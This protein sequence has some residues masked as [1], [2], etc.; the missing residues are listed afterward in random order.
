MSDTRRSAG[1]L[2]NGSEERS[3]RLIG[4]SSKSYWRLGDGLHWARA[5]VAAAERGLETTGMYACVPYP[6]VAPLTE[7]L[8]PTD[9]E[10]GTQDVSAHPPGAYTGEVSAAL[11]ADLGV[12]Y[13]MVGH[14]ERRRYLSETPQ[15]I[16]E[17]AN[18]AAEAGLT[19]ILVCGEESEGQDPG[20]ILRSQLEEAFGDFDVSQ[21]V[22][23]A[24]EPTW[25]IGAAEPA[26]AEHIVRTVATL[27]AVLDEIL[28]AAEIVYG[29]SAQ[30]G[31]FRAIAEAAQRLEEP[32]G[33][34]AGVFMGRAGLD[35]QSY[36]NAANEVIEI[37]KLY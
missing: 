20:P 23:A 21:R 16:R 3:K 14:P 28:P 22:V 7:I 37:T 4:V 31:T 17:K 29:G 8:E 26:P 36:L 15:V 11:L 35:P 19:P 12:R 30:V 2:G 34:P 27:R 5:V 33:V 9:V 25:A 13:V 1:H 18:R 10:I 24:Y 6:L 32:A